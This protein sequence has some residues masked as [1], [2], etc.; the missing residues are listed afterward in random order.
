MGDGLILV[1][2]HSNCTSFMIH[3]AYEMDVEDEN[4]LYHKWIDNTCM[5][6]IGYK[7]LM[8]S[9]LIWLKLD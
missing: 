4:Y 6:S 3:L 5:I 9:T 1:S 8:L 2:K 7:P